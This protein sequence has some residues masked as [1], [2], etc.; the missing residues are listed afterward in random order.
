M[1]KIVE[2][3]RPGN[4]SKHLDER[5]SKL[6]HITSHLSLGVR[7][8]GVCILVVHSL[9]TGPHLQSA[10]FGPQ[11]THLPVRKSTGP[12]F[13]TALT[14]III[15]SHLLTVVVYCTMYFVVWNY[16]KIH[17]AVYYKR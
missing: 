17:G 9:P 6:I 12:H 15:G 7:L 10:S 5:Y 2:S 14:G 13:T 3:S 4:V 1:C 16:N 11:F 8:H